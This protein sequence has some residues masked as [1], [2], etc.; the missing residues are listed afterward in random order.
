MLQLEHMGVYIHLF[1]TTIHNIK[2][3]ASIQNSSIT[4]LGVCCVG[5]WRKPD[6]LFIYL[7]S[8]KDLFDFLKG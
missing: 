7:F 8:I 6:Y 5:G 1:S 2:I 3:I 4:K